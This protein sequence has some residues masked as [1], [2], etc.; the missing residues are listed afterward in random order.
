MKISPSNPRN[1]S[2]LRHWF[3]GRGHALTLCLSL[4]CA[5]EGLYASNTR[6][7]LK[8]GDFVAICGDSITQQQLYSAFIESYLLMCKP[9]PDLEAMCMGWSGETSLTFL[10]RMDNDAIPFQPSVVTLC[11]GMND[12]GHTPLNAKDAS[13]YRDC[14]TQ[15]VEN[16]QKAGTRAIVVGSPGAVDTVA[17]TKSDPAI[18]NDNLKQLTVIAKE[19]ASKTGTGFVD[20]HSLM[21]DV[22]AK[23]KAKF[24]SSYHVAG[25]DGVHPAANGHIIMAYAFLK[26]LGCHGEIGTITVD[27]KTGTAEGSTGHKI[28]S[29]SAGKVEVESEKYPFCFAGDPTSPDSPRGVLEFLPFNQDLNR[30]NLVVK[31]APS[32]RMKV[33]WGGQAKVFSAAELERGINLASEFPENPF[34]EPFSKIQRAVVA[35]QSFDVKAVKFMQHSI[36]YWK[37]GLPEFADDY[38]KL[39]EALIQKTETERKKVGAMVKPVKHTIALEEAS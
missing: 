31:N 19:V 34:C 30:F 3:S 17:H 1:L 2:G 9:E 4:I 39:S 14:M 32:A 18:R 23:A 20:I 6:V 38:K 37:E 26:A 27:G 36:M 15:I 5:L 10:K 33:I 12:G 25:A 16:F 24:G 28:L 8:S 22:M 21:L 13:R 7:E 11:F 29:S 35:Q